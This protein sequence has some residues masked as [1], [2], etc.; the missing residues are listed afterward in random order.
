MLPAETGVFFS[1]IFVGT[2]VFAVSFIAL[3]LLIGFLTRAAKALS[4]RKELKSIGEVA[5][6]INLPVIVLAALLSAYAALA[7]AAPE[8][9]NSPAMRIWVAGVIIV[10]VT[11]VAKALF[12][13]LDDY[14]ESRQ[15]HG[16][17]RS[18][19][20]IKMALNFVLGLVAFLL[21]IELFEPG[22]GWIVALFGAILMLCLF[23]LFYAP[24]KNLVSG[25]QLAG[26][27]LKPG[28][29]VEFSG[30]GKGTVCEIGGRTTKLLCEDGALL[31]VPNALAAS[32]PIKSYSCDGI[33]NLC[34]LAF[35][36]ET[37]DVEKARRAIE[38][39]S[40]RIADG[41]EGINDEYRPAV[42]LIGIEAMQ[43]RFSVRFMANQNAD[44]AAAK[45]AMIRGI[46]RMLKKE[47]IAL[48]SAG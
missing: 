4:M 30:I 43:C 44:V 5:D 34:V 31:L 46:S 15:Q 45:A 24:M 37:Q 48:N 42:R 2:A 8:V 7:A 36:C 22:I 21:F 35:S 40:H 1:E 20:V 28:D 13:F 10:G 41:S 11:I 6:D 18:L 23:A 25:M 14:A 12:V 27:G 9:I 38:T 47:G 16:M 17:R 3:F 19:P 32:L 29:Y 39:A 33:G 26:K